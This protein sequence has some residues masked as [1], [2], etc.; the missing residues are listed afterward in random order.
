MATKNRPTDGE[1][2][3]LIVLWERGSL[4]VR[5]VNEALSLKRKVGY[6]TTLKIM[7]IMTEKGLLVR[8]VEQRTHVYSAAVNEVDT[9]KRM[10]DRFLDTAF[11][12]SAQKLVME[13]LGNYQ[14]TPDELAEI[15]KLI[16]KLERDGNA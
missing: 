11:S 4:T 10:L 9:K 1:L 2:E 5:E 7:Q 16:E 12:G 14:A 8:N 15:K 3:I 13:A 6:T